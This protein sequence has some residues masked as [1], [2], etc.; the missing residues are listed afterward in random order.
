[1][2]RSGASPI[3]HSPAV[4]MARPASLQLLFGA[5]RRDR[6]EPLVDA[7]PRRGVRAP[8]RE[9]VTQDARMVENTK[10]RGESQTDAAVDA[11]DGNRVDLPATGN[12]ASSS[13]SQN[14]SLFA[15]KRGDYSTEPS[16]EY[17]YHLRADAAWFVVLDGG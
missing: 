16:L 13:E 3:K 7:A 15:A 9:R 5:G 14:L 17:R 12:L 2:G 6:E 1:M 8:P 10:A 11:V 4:R